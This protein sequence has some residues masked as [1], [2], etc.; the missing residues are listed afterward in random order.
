MGKQ[1]GLHCPHTRMHSAF[2]LRQ[3]CRKSRS[4]LRVMRFMIQHQSRGQALPSHHL[5][6]V[7]TICFLNI[8]L[9]ILLARGT[10]LGRQ[11]NRSGARSL[12]TDESCPA[13]TD[14]PWGQF[15]DRGP[16]VP[17]GPQTG[18]STEGWK[19]PLRSSQH[20]HGL[21]SECHLKV[22]THLGCLTCLTLPR[23]VLLLCVLPPYLH[24][25]GHLSPTCVTRGLLDKGLTLPQLRGFKKSW[26]VMGWDG[27]WSLTWF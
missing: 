5:G 20:L 11:E 8:S 10:S 24:S 22:G 4:Q 23:A 2:T 15:G 26:A 9:R 1:R 16:G 18:E 17:G 21:E 14:R 6:S 12:K 7:T 27:S 13:G 19:C 25:C 3:I